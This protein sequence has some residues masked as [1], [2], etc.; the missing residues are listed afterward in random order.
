M[1]AIKTEQLSSNNLIII[2]LLITLLVVGVSVLVGKSMVTTIVRD[3]KVLDKKNAAKEQLT[4]N[5]EAAP[6][7]I[8]SY[9]QLKEKG[10]VLAD[11]LP[12]NADFPSLIVTLENMARGAGLKLKSVTPSQ[13][14]ATDEDGGAVAVGNVLA[15]VAQP[16]KFGIA[17][18]GGYA[19]LGKLLGELETSARPMR[20]LDIQLTGGGSALSGIMNVET[21]YQDKAELPFSKETVK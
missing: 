6:G 14:A 8:E 3:Q 19:G 12:N 2:V 10:V 18:S 1:A 21:Y 15:P 5:I 9:G 11:A 17:F 13:V 7:L 4:K 20:V 16:Y